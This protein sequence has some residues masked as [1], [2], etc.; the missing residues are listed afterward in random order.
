MAALVAMLHRRSGLTLSSKMLATILLVIAIFIW[1]ANWP[2]MK[3]GLNFVG[4]LWFSALRFL[5]GCLCLF[6]IQIW[7]GQLKLPSKQDL[8]LVMS[9]GLIQM[10]LFTA[11][12]AIAMTQI[13]AGRSAILAYTTPLWVT[14]AA[15]LL[16]GER[17]SRSEKIGFI[18]GVIGIVVLL[19]PASLN[20]HSLEDILPYAMLLGGSLCWASCILHLKYSNSKATVYQLAPW[21]MLLAAIPLCTLAAWSEGPLHISQIKEFSLVL[22]FVGPLATAFCFVA[23]NTASRWLSST[24]MSFSM[25]GV[26]VVGLVLS[27]IVLNEK[28]TPSL[29][30]GTLTIL[31]GIVFISLAK[32][33]AHSK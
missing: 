18:S 3:Y 13:D 10:M 19:N 24:N 33:E 8:P 1:G 14:P 7:L 23:V 22:L 11:L 32:K 20:F 12:G 28:L 29:A 17:L 6:A 9:V 16:F 4:P 15:V 27:L 5:T 26:P 30:L 31:L 2:M 21:Q 25:L